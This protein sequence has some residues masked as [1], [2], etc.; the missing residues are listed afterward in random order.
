MC[1]PEEARAGKHMHTLLGAAESSHMDHT[2]PK[3]ADATQ[4]MNDHD[5]RQ[6]QR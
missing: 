6:R 1:K 2:S 4:S 3:K 5:A